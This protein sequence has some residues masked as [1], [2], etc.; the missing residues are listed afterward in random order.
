MKDEI[1]CGRG[2]I[3]CKLLRIEGIGWWMKN[4]RNMKRIGGLGVIRIL[5]EW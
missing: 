5:G 1:D 2:G 4:G 3:S